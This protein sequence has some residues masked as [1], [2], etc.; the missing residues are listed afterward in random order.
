MQY[1]LLSPFLA[2]TV[3]FFYSLRDFRSDDV[4]VSCDIIFVPLGRSFIATIVSFSFY[5][6]KYMLSL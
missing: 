4:V 5:Y 1:S 3:F 2:F 6:L